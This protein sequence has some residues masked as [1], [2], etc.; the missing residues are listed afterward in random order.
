MFLNYVTSGFNHVIPFGLDH[1]LFIVVLFFLSKNAMNA[2][3]QAL[4]FTLAHSITLA[5]VV[6]GYIPPSMAWTESLIAFS[7]F[8]VA[9]EN[10]YE[11]MFKQW[12]YSIVFAFG[13]LHGLGF[14]NALHEVGIQSDNIGSALLGFN[15][16]VELAQALII[17]LLHGLVAS[18][19]KNNPNYNQ[20]IIKPISIGIAAIAL[21]WSVERFLYYQ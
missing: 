7:I 6:L 21:F 8:L 10:I 17:V 4:V 19:F 1:V 12:R 15:I 11:P 14:A 20:Y 2:V 13:L 5:L 9:L 3:R 18:P 16:G